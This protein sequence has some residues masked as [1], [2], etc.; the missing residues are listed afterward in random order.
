M[1][2]YGHYCGLARALDVVG[3][4]WTLL[5]VRELLARGALRYKDL[6]HGLP[7]IASN[8]LVNRLR[9]MEESGLVVREDAPPPIATTLFRLTP[10]GEALE[11]V[12]SSLGRWAGP[13]MSEV[14]SDDAMRTHWYGL[15]IRLYFEDAAPS[16]PPVSLA[17]NIGD[18][19][20][21]LVE[22]GAG[23]IKT[24][25]GSSD[26]ADA[27]LQG[28]PDMIMSV[29]SRRIALSTA[30]RRGVLF[31]GDRSVLNRIRRRQV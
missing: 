22:V 17:L 1:R 6:E 7:G 3:D 12:I 21:L 16:G 18:D 4:R 14:R 9:E 28:A 31:R 27:V 15:P 8:M 25:I 5:I 24:R 10:R 23:E 2:S 19:E 11:S 13:L 20:S 29:L 30:M 26:G